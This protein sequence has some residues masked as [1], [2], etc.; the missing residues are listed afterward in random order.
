M[1]C[2]RCDE[3][4]V[5]Y[6]RYSGA[7]L[8]R[9]H[10]MD[11]F[12]KRVYKEFRKQVELRGGKRIGVAVSGGK[13]SLVALRMIHDILE[14]RRDCEIIGI[15]IDEGIDGYRD[16]SVEIAEKEYKKLGVDH[17]IVSFKE[18]FGH[19]LDDIV[20]V[21]MPCSVC[22]V[23][24][25]WLLNTTAKRVEA[26]YLATGLNLDDTA[27][28]ILMNFCRGDVDKLSRLGP[29]EKVKEGLV[30]RIAPLRRTPENESYLYA[31]CAGLSIHDLECP[32][33]DEALRGLYRDV[34]GE[35]E[36]NTPGTKYAILSS[37]DKLNPLLTGVDGELGV[38]EDCGEPT[39]GEL[40]KACELLESIADLSII[41]PGA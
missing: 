25:R 14:E 3:E 20:D 23:L 39:S 27:Q 9:E 24:R 5:I 21:G 30:P 16:S 40:C 6:I 19:R 36:D 37:Y 12:H 38:C 22:G 34:L 18:E 1:Q 41:E 17:E 10:F 15:T 4:A 11:F 13:D 35:L 8:C 29:H 28:S 31:M 7:H 33:A 2:S 26:D 32:Y